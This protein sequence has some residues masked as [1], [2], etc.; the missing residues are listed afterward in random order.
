[1]ASVVY[2]ST[3]MGLRPRIYKDS[4]PESHFY[5]VVEVA[6]AISLWQ[7]EIGDTTMYLRN[8]HLS[9]FTMR[10]QETKF[11]SGSSV[12]VKLKS[13][14]ICPF[15]NYSNINQLFKNNFSK[16]CTNL[17]S[18]LYSSV[19]WLIFLH[20][21]YLATYSVCPSDKWEWRSG[22]PGSLTVVVWTSIAQLLSV[23]NSTEIEGI[24]TLGIGHLQKFIPGSLSRVGSLV[25]LDSTSLWYFF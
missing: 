16:L 21:Q 7:Y 6:W 15:S 11:N 10:Q 25:V 18:N 20:N 17:Y 3:S 22:Q 19:P 13:P 4:S 9:I 2:L 8:G 24:V 14:G 1:M 12:I 5:L 23:V